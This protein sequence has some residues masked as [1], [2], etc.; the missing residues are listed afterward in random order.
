M[1]FYRILLERQ[2]QLHEICI[3]LVLCRVFDTDTYTTH[4]DT[5]KKNSF[6]RI[7]HGYH[8]MNYEYFP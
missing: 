8:I 6:S 7:E 5:H 2:Q 4:A 1:M 3:T